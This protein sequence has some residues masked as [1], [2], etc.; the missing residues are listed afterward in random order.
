MSAPKTLS[1]TAG[2]DAQGQR[3]DLYMVAAFQGMSRKKAKKLIDARRVSVNGKIEHMAGREL[4]PGDRVEARD[5]EEVKKE[6][7]LSDLTVLYDDGHIVA[8]DKP[9]GLVSGPTRD[10]G[11]QHAEK[12]AKERLGGK[13]TLL[14][15]LDRDTSGVLL[16]ARSEEAGKGLLQAFKAREVAKTYLAL[17]SGDTP[18]EF[19]DVCHLKEA[20]NSR[21]VVVSSGGMRAETSFKTLLRGKGFC[22]VEARPKTGRMHQIRVSLSRLGYPIAGD[23]LYGGAAKV[24]EG[25]SAFLA[26]RQLLH[27]WKAGFK[28]PKTLK[29]TEI[30]S[31]VPKDFLSAAKAAFGEK[32]KLLLSD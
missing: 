5:E 19:S 24:G 3:L 17:V 1:S 10:S 8:V 11:R 4:T 2:K 12:L 26:A 6:A 7:P 13:L 32:A 20:P 22:L 30:K 27:A 16:L 25:E 15:R 18:D 23:A 29:F 9:P 31:P 14:H 28:H 21:V